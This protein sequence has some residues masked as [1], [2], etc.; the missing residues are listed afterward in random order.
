MQDNDCF[1]LGNMSMAEF[2]EFRSLMIEMVLHTGELVC[3]STQLLLTVQSVTAH[4]LNLSDMSM[5]FSQL[6]HMKNLVQT[7]ADGGRWERGL[8]RT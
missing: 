5:H 3:F 2:R 1:I 6:K 8:I 7:A 4:Q